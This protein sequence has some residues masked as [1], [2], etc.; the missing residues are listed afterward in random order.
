MTA[1]TLLYYGRREPIP[2]ALELRAGP[3]TMSFDPA[4]GFLRHIRLGDHEIVRNIY[5]AVRDHDWTTIPPHVTNLISEI[6]EDAFRLSFDVSYRQGEVDYFW[7][8][9]V[10]GT[11]EGKVVY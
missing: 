4:N 9:S 8:G 2:K 7:R 5:G 3:L 10:T 1:P 6:S 11:A